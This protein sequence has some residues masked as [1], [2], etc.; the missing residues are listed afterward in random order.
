VDQPVILR[1]EMED[2]KR[3]FGSQAKV[4]H[5][6]GKS[7]EW[8]SRTLAALSRGEQPHLEFKTELAIHYLHSFVVFATRRIGTDVSYWLFVPREE[9][10]LAEP[11]ALLRQGRLQEVVDLLLRELGADRVAAPAESDDRP[12]QSAVF[13]A[14]ERPRRLRLGGPRRQPPA[15]SELDRRLAGKRFDLEG[16]IYGS[17]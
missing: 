4:A 9:L 11:A 13:R 15:L 7:E 10:G 8:T 6:L 2:L 14:R 17:R 12:R 16:V 3:S 1:D 5:A